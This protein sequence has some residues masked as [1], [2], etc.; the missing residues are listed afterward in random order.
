M[1]YGWHGTHS[2][3]AVADMLMGTT[4]LPSYHFIKPPGLTLAASIIWI[5]HVTR[6]R[7]KLPVETGWEGQRGR[8]MPVPRA[9]SPPP[10]PSRAD[11]T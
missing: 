9:D 11:Q 5:L 8:V 1:L 4:S 6:S 2:A 7:A 3:G 10:I